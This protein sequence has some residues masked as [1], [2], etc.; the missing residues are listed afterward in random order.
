MDEVE[1]QHHD[2]Q[3]GPHPL[4]NTDPRTWPI[5]YTYEGTFDPLGNGYYEY[6]G[7]F[8]INA[9]GG[10]KFTRHEVVSRSLIDFM[11]MGEPEDYIR[12]AKDIIVPVPEVPKEQLDYLRTKLP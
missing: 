1:Q 7:E 12:V 8:E 6:S 11:K 3:I 2:Q 4:P 10:L 5:V 9:F